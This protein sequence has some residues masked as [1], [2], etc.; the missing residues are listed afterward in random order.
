MAFL[1]EI[2]AST[3]GRVEAARRERSFENVEREAAAA[4]APRDLRGALAGE[5]VALIAE[6]KRATPAL[7]R[8]AADLQAGPTAAAYARAGAA[9]VSVLTEPSLFEGALEDLAPA[10]E[11]GLPL[12]RKD[13]LV[14]TYQVYEARAAGA[15]AVLVIVRIVPG[16]LLGELV[17]VARSLGMTPLVEV[18]D[19]TDLKRA[20]AAGADVI[21]I[22]HRDLVSFDVDESRTAKLAPMAPAGAAVVA[23]SGVRD[24]AGVEAMMEAGASAVLVGEAL[25]TAPDPEAKIRELLGR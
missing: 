19:E 14:D 5:E 13:F 1:D 16:S 4:P 2:L 21:G 24:R 12:L 7:G 9:A 15:D 8:I 22:N 6:I 3:Q 18:Y 10:R 11:A 17:D 23:L 20:A 25:V